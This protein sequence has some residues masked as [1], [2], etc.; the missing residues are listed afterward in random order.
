MRSEEYES[1][2]H[3]IFFQAEDGIRDGTVTGVQTCALPILEPGPEENG[4]GI[5]AGAK[6]DPRDERAAHGA[7]RCD[8]LDLHGAEALGQK[9]LLDDIPP[10]RDAVKLHRARNIVLAEV[11]AEAAEK[12]LGLLHADAADELRGDRVEA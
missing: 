9:E 8:E 12:G 10:A 7:R 11:I 2:R 4:R 6:A 5:F 3:R 1:F